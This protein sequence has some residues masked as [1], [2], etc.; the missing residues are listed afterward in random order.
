MNALS[1]RRALFGVGPMAAFGAILRRTRSLR[2]MRT[3][4]PVQASHPFDIECGTDTAGFRSWRE[5]RS[6]RKNDPY[7]AGYLPAD[8]AVGS[9]LLCRVAAPEQYT[10]L[11]LGCG[12]GRVLVLASGIGFRR[13]IGIEINPAL[14]EIAKQNAAQVRA[15]FPERAPIEVV[16]D[17]AAAMRFPQE[18]LVIFLNHPFWV[19]VMRQVSSSLAM[20]LTQAPREAFI[21]YVNPVLS[22]VF[23][24]M[25]L[26]ERVIIA[27]SDAREEEH[28][29]VCVRDER[30]MEHIIWRT[31]VPRPRLAE[32]LA[33]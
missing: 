24:A 12:K 31:R 26:L 28:P 3:L 11:D 20:S 30:V 15:R 19:P 22:E 4:R 6:G 8:P 18:P 9:D 1:L 2:T 32:P 27:P 29:G 13:V 10:F 7:N 14:S 23:D 5:L 33:H 17:D 16:L 25:P 21:L